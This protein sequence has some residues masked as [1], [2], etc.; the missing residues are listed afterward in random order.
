[1][2]FFQG[3]DGVKDNAYIFVG[4]NGVR[5][6]TFKKVASTNFEVPDFS[7]RRGYFN[8]IV[9]SKSCH[10]CRKCESLIYRHETKCS[11]C[12]IDI[13]WLKYV[14]PDEWSDKGV[15][16]NRDGRKSYHI[17]P[18]IVTDAD[19]DDEELIRFKKLMS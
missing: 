12:G 7:D 10:P 9:D 16:I 8:K 15:F 18:R 2:N 6:R 13:E 5:Y 1:M 11:N 3:I 4:L 17:K 19:E 14:S